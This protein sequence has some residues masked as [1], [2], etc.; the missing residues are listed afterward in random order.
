MDLTR[1]HVLAG[2][3]ATAACAAMP[4]G[5]ASVTFKPPPVKG[6]HVLRKVVKHHSGT[7][8][9]AKIVLR[10]LAGDVVAVEKVSSSTA[11]SPIRRKSVSAVENPLRR[12]PAVE[13]RLRRIRA[14][15]NKA[16]E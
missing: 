2:A 3:A 5:A 9:I 14:Q 1:R 11:S 15:N 10:A 7:D 8:S 16:P 13:N 4:A 6:W 12:R